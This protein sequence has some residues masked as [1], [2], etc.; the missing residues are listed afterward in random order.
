[1]RHRKRTAP[2]YELFMMMTGVSS[3]RF[4]APLGSRPPPTTQPV[5]RTARRVPTAS[6]KRP[7]ATAK[8]A[9]RRDIH[10]YVPR[11]DGLRVLQPRSWGGPVEQNSSSDL[12][13]VSQG[14]CPEHS[15]TSD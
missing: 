12:L 15:P 2:R 11:Y 10:I 5:A 4:A 7:S 9:K 1:M 13:R 3:S 6:P 14:N 8:G